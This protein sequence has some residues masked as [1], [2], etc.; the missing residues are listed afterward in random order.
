[1]S[2]SGCGTFT[3]GDNDATLLEAARRGDSAAIATLYER[4]AGMIHAL[5][6]MKLRREDA[7][8][9][10]HDVF[11]KALRKIHVLAR[12]RAVGHYLAAMAR[13]HARDLLRRRRPA[14]SLDGDVA[15]PAKPEAE[16]LEVLEALRSLP[17]SQAE[18]LAMRLVEGMT[19]PEIAERT[20][21]SHAAV[22]VALHRGMKALRARLGA[23][24]RP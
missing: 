19:G 4:Y 24:E 17:A 7:E 11:L 14:A 2:E 18:P 1:V 20:G 5:L 8:D 12:S 22:R 6:L 15:A 23:E 21:M 13:N 9:G 3:G 16:A 10:V